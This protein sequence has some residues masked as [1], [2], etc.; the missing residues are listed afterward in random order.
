MLERTK[1][2][3]YEV[4]QVVVVAGV[5]RYEA[6]HVVLPRRA[7]IEVLE[8]TASRMLA[9]RLMRHACILEALHHPG[10]PRVFEC[11][12]LE[13]RPWIAFERTDGITLE[14]DLRAR[15]LDVS[16]VLDVIEQVATILTHSHARG[17]LHR[18]ITPSAI[19]RDARRG[20]VVLQGWANA[21]TL[22]TELP[23][24][25]RGT[26][27]YRAPELLHDRPA[28]VRAD[29]FALGRIAYEALTG[30]APFHPGLATLITDMVSED[31]TSR[32]AA[33]EVVARVRA[34]R[35]ESVPQPWGID[36]RV[37]LAHGIVE[38]VPRRR[39]A[40]SD[41]DR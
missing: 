17:V 31:P 15:R 26:H 7:I 18:D 35:A 39:R 5:V 22:D 14:S 8:P 12:M 4:Q 28:D 38:I 2:G 40:V 19:I 27:R 6:T 30:R 3:D 9:V 36:T 10:V 32:P 21:C 24:L 25:L 29:I 13:G 20:H 1:I 23:G 16:E 41:R 34:I 33:A 37:A 11:G